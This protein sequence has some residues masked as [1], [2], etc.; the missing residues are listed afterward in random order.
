MD[1][2]WIFNTPGWCIKMDYWLKWI[3]GFLRHLWK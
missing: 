3:N 1:F 2:D